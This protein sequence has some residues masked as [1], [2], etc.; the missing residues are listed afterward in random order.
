MTRNLRILACIILF[1]AF[2]TGGWLSFAHKRPQ[3]GGASANA[4]LP[5]FT[6][7]TAQ[8]ATTPQLAFWKAVNDG[9]T[10]K[11][12]NLQVEFWRDLDSLKTLLIAGKGDL[13]LG[14]LEGFALAKKNGA[15]L[16]L[17][18]VTGWKKFYLLSTNPNLSALKD[19]RGRTLAYCPPGS[20]A[21]PVIKTLL[22]DVAAT[23][24][25]VPQGLAEVSQHLSDNTYDS[26]VIPE[27]LGTALLH[28]VKNLRVVLNLEEAYGSAMGH[29]P[30]LPLVGIAVNTQ[31]A[32]KYP[33]AIDALLDLLLMKGH[34]LALDPG[35]ASDVL[36]ESVVQSLGRDVIAESLGRD[37]VLVK[38]AAE[39][40][41]EIVDYLRI[42]EPAL[43]TK[44]GKL[45][46]PPSFIWHAQSTGPS[47]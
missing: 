43:I 6:F 22:G 2:I 34:E 31:T 17:I 41:Q 12:F 15:P 35:Q 38:S 13:W 39:V 25:F 37:L 26:V 30:R 16:S 36:P 21:V 14:H 19:Y 8:T 3:A 5:T 32:A 11:L 7:Y 20:P 42:I 23:V 46:L 27:P 18:A 24:S 45:A 29:P 47:E 44:D 40:E 9:D 28:K 4:E 33:Q 1:L 10:A